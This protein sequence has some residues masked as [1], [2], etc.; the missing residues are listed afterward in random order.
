MAIIGKGNC[1][2][3]RLFAGTW[4]SQ[5]FSSE[6]EWST[7]PTYE[8]WKSSAVIPHESDGKT[9]LDSGSGSG[10]GGRWASNSFICLFI[11]LATDIFKNWFIAELCQL[12]RQYLI[13]EDANFW[14]A[15]I[16]KLAKI[17]EIMRNMT[18]LNTL[19]GIFIKVQFDINLSLEVQM[20][21]FK[22]CGFI[23]QDDF[24][25]YIIGHIYWSSLC[26]KM[27]SKNLNVCI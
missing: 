4:K 3:A 10:W 16:S 8:C 18:L 9:C 17:K 23:L 14:A 11:C 1:P 20:F 27:I 6:L 22:Y 15:F 19:L 24:I 21:K 7:W 13:D 2:S 12:T 5:I 26:Y 25:E